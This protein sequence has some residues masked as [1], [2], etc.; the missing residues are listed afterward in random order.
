MKDFEI[1]CKEF[2][3]P[4]YVLPPYRPKYNGR[5]ERSNRTIREVFYFK[6]NELKYCAKLGEIN[7]KL[8]EFIYKYN[9]YR[10][11]QSRSLTYEERAVGNK[12]DYK[13]PME[14]F[15]K[16]LVKNE[17]IFSQML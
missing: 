11:N 1:A 15:N 10:P 2:N 3:I 13:T 8:Q 5:V 12:H 7:E 16:Y 4:L 6:N 9:N 14:Y 17:R